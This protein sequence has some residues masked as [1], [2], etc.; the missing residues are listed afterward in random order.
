MDNRPARGMYTLMKTIIA[1]SRNIKSINMIY[2]AIKQ[3][4]YDITEIVSGTAKGVDKLGE[5]YAHENN[6]P[7]ARFPADWSD[8]SHPDAI[9]RTNRN[10][11]EYDARAGFRRNMK[12]AEYA[13]ALIAIWDGDSKGTYQMIEYAVEK[14]L[15]VKVFVPDKHGILQEL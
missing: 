15:H 10:N 3:S 8:L 13:D 9:I 5:Q 4:C 6:I 11:Y 12:M 7:V 2:E 14:G 1:G